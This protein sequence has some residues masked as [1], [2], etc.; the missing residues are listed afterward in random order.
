MTGD[1]RDGTTYRVLLG[2]YDHQPI[3]IGDIEMTLEVFSE[4]TREFAS[5]LTKKGCSTAVGYYL[6]HL[7]N[8]AATKR[9]VPSPT[10]VS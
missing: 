2:D 8:V 10:R 1:P 6:E 7:C 4:M 3:S 9:I 5:R